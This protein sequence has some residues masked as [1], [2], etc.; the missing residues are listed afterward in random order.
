MPA[1]DAAGVRGQVREHDLRDF[2]AS[3][4]M[5]AGATALEVRDALGHANVRTT[6][7]HYL[8]QVQDR[9]AELADRMPTL[10]VPKSSNVT[11]ITRNTGSD[12]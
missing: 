3:H 10:P 6:V 8:H 7:D 12:F 2:S 1:Q 4:L 9:A 11:K 5:A